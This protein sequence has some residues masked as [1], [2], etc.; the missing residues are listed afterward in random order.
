MH[1]T[2]R[3]EGSDERGEAPPPYLPGSKRLSVRVENLG[4]HSTSSIDAGN[5]EPVMMDMDGTRP[6][7]Y[8]E[9]TDLGSGEGL[10]RLETAVTA[11]GR[12]ASMRRSMGS[13]GSWDH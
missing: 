2:G 8:H 13:S 1:S 5:M 10:S 7:G 6:P 3:E 9:N 11:S 12:F 4:R